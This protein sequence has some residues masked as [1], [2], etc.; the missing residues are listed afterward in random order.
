MRKDFLCIMKFTITALMHADI[1][2]QQNMALQFQTHRFWGFTLH[3]I[4]NINIILIQHQLGKLYFFSFTLVGIKLFEIVLLLDLFQALERTCV[5]NKKFEQSTRIFIPFILCYS[6][7]LLLMWSWWYIWCI[8]GLCWLRLMFPSRE[9]MDTR[10]LLGSHGL[11]S[12][13]AQNHT[14]GCDF[15]DSNR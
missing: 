7:M 1:W 14:L 11:I 4:I 2:E 15:S 9:L 6:L 12:V 8:S 10:D 3:N 5:F 13:S